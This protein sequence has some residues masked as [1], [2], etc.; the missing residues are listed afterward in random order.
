MGISQSYMGYQVPFLVM[1][2]RQPIGLMVVLI[3][4]GGL[5]WPSETNTSSLPVALGLGIALLVSCSLF[6][7][8]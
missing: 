6:V 8:A 7:S 1:L 2:M 5:S 4:H 3:R